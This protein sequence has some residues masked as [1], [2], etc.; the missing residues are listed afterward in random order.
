MES[1]RGCRNRV[2]PKLTDVFRL[3]Y[4]KEFKR[5]GVKYSGLPKSSRKS[6]SIQHAVGGFDPFG[7]R[8]DVSFVPGGGGNGGG[9]GGGGM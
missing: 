8:G 1:F 6:G 2:K 5:A 7:T 9:N 3:V 4:E